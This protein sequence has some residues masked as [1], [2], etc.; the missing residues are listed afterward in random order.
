[1]SD[2]NLAELYGGYLCSAAADWRRLGEMYQEDDVEFLLLR[3]GP[4]DTMPLIH[5]DTALAKL[6]RAR[7][8]HR[9]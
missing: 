1:M 5:R 3:P 2:R 7:V 8:V 6:Q 4:S 9:T